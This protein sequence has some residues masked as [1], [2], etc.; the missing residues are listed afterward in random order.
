MSFINNPL[1]QG[2]FLWHNQPIIEPQCAFHILVETSD[3]W[4]TLSHSSVDMPHAFI[5][6]WC[7]N[8]LTPQ[9]RCE[10]VVVQ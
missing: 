7:S 6:F 5:M 4:I 10:S 1:F 8:D 2:F 9:G 3:L